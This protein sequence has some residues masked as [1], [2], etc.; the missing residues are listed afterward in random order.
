MKGRDGDTVRKHMN[1][2]TFKKP[3]FANSTPGSDQCFVQRLVTAAYKIERES[4]NEYE[5]SLS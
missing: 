2:M 5:K 3:L 1:V 4:E